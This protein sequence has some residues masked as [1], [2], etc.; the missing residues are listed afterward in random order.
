MPSRLLLCCTWRLRIL[1]VPAHE[2]KMHCRSIYDPKAAV[3]RA[4]RGQRWT[5][6]TDAKPVGSMSL[7]R[8]G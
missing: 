5:N 1:L 4:V 2:Q 6:L 3:S 8:L 7:P